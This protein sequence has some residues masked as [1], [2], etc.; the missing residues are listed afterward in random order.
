MDG[1]QYKENLTIISGGY[2]GEEIGSDGLVTDWTDVPAS[3]GSNTIKYWYRDSDSGNNNNSSRV[4]I[5]VTDSWSITRNADRSYT[6]VASSTIDSIVRDDIRGTPGS[7]T[8]NIFIR[9]TTGGQILW[10][11]TGDNISTAHTI[12]T[13]ISLGSETFTLP[14]NGGETSQGTIYLRNNT[15]GHDGDPTPSAYVDE[16]WVGTNFRNMLPRDYRPGMTYNGTNW[17]SHNRASGAAGIYNGSSFTEMRTDSGDGIVT[18]NPPYIR[19][20]SDWVNQR[21]IGQDA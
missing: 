20:S 10:S 12:A 6:V 14:P 21:L 11:T 15:A 4:V 16:F 9:R 7:T 8:R 19:S 17:M 2:S 13:N 5:E 18:G 1:L 3:T